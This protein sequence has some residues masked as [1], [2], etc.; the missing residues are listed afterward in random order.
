MLTLVLLPGMDGTGKLFAGLA[1][2]LGAGVDTLV[3]AY[4]PTTALDYPAL[5]Q[6]VRARLPADRDF[7]LLAES[8]S[9]PL[10]IAIGAAPPPRLRA[11]V[12]CCTFARSPAPRLAQ[13]ARL[14]AP[15]ASTR[16]ACL[17][18]A[19]MLLGRFASLALCGQLWQALRGVSVAVLR[20][21]LGAVAT[22]DATAALASVTLP[23]LV[24]QAMQ[25]RVVMAGAT[26]L[27]MQTCPG[28]T[29]LQVDGPHLLLQARPRHMAAALA[30]WL[31]AGGDPPV[32]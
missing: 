8:F 31:R 7:V 32:S 11:V 6:W 2:A 29:L 3:I 25:D 16:P 21:R 27:L 1:A 4:P 10:A 12:L 26:Q 9:G 5:V 19:P 15:A 30:P 20:A 28:A 14:F 18:A 13:L 17:L 22:V 23:L 24:I